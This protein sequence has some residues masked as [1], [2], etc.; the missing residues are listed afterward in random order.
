MQLTYH[1]ELNRFHTTTPERLSMTC[2]DFSEAIDTCRELSAWL[3]DT[4]ESVSVICRRV[5]V[6]ENGCEVS[7]S[8]IYKDSSY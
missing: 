5:E 8:E 3:R 7:E 6:T 2:K 1:I 4:V